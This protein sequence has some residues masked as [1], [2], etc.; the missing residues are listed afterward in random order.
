MWW[1]RR[2]IGARRSSRRSVS[3]MIASKQRGNARTPSSSR[4]PARADV[5]DDGTAPVSLV[6]LLSEP[7]FLDEFVLDRQARRALKLDDA[8]GLDDDRLV[9]GDSPTFLVCGDRFTFL[10]NN[11]AEP[12]V[13]N[14]DAVGEQIEDMRLRK[15]VRDHRAWIS[16]DLVSVEFVRGGQSDEQETSDDD[17]GDDIFA[18]K[19]GTEQRESTLYGTL[20]RKDSGDIHPAELDE[21][22]QWMG[23]LIAELADSDCLAIF[24]PT[25][26]QLN[27]YDAALEDQLRSKHPLDVFAEPTFLPVVEIDQQAA[28]VQLAIAEAQRRWPEFER[29][30]G[31]RKREQ[32]FAV[33]APF[34]QNDVTEFM[35]LIVTAIEHNVIYGR[36][37]NDPVGVSRLRHGDVVRVSVDHV[38][39]WLFHSSDRLVGG[40][41]LDAARGRHRKSFER[42]G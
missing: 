36:L 2:S 37:D 4:T 35:W 18:E 29:A 28:S 30:F 14:L 7:R 16:V 12:Y 32:F 42:N 40:F 20:S 17:T 8:I 10:V 5:E 26:D 15:A 33:K 41:T 3:D 39:D 27:I 23:R 22:Y 38:N 13:E 31:C 9:I 25:T 21:A 24:S 19:T 11:Y 6:L 1:Q 34:C